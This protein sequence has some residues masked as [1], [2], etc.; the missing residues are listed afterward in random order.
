MGSMIGTTGK[1][2]SSSSPLHSLCS[3]GVV[4]FV[5]EPE[6]PHLPKHPLRL[7][8]QPPKQGCHMEGIK[9]LN[10]KSS[11]RSAISAHSQ[12][13]T[14]FLS[15]PHIGSSESPAAPGDK[16]CYIIVHHPHLTSLPQ[17][18]VKRCGPSFPG[19]HFLPPKKDRWRLGPWGR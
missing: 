8:A 11:V 6:N 9:F 12:A 16:V 13:G 1:A 2:S 15:P 4:K 3:C 17:H 18:G 19:P 7:L 14:P 5:S 10:W